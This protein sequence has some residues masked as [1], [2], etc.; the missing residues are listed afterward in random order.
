[1]S[2]R[3]SGR[4]S[5][6][7]STIDER[8]LLLETPNDPDD[9]HL[10]DCEDSKVSIEQSSVQDKRPINDAWGLLR[11]KRHS[12]SAEMGCRSDSQHEKSVP[13]EKIEVKENL[14]ELTSWCHFQLKW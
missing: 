6:P 4:L 11:N 8:G 5:I 10:I 13:L 1:M 9:E 2:S 3:L 12:T 7:E 14:W